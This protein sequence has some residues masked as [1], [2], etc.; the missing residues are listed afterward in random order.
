MAYSNKVTITVEVPAYPIKEVKL[1]VSTDGGNWSTDASG[2]PIYFEA[3]AYDSNGNLADTTIEGITNLA[4][5]TDNIPYTLT[6][7]KGTQTTD[8]MINTAGGIAVWKVETVEKICCQFP[9]GKTTGQVSALAYPMFT[10]NNYLINSNDVTVDYASGVNTCTPARIDL[11]LYPSPDLVTLNC[12]G[13]V[14]SLYQLIPNKQYTWN[15]QVT[16]S[17]GNDCPYCML[18]GDFVSYFMTGTYNSDKTITTDQYGKATITWTA[19]YKND[20]PYATPPFETQCVNNIPKVYFYGIDVTNGTIPEHVIITNS[21]PTSNGYYGITANMT[22]QGAELV[23]QGPSNENLYILAYD[24]STGT[25][26]NQLTY[27][28]YV[29]DISSEGYILKFITQELSAVLVNGIATI[30]LKGVLNS[31]IYLVLASGCVALN[32]KST[33]IIIAYGPAVPDGYGGY[34]FGGGAIACYGTIS[35]GVC[36]QSTV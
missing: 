1:Y 11:S 34:T 33:P 26:S 12:Y 25:V 21:L 18:S 4:V 15:I 3:E 17:D 22:D 28:A 7:L 23:I 30:P 36:Q 29:Y 27:S 16:D 20:L 14:E 24:I 31:T 32:Y 10:K 2:N 8:D 5:I 19:P 35:N 6:V 9:Q 13:S